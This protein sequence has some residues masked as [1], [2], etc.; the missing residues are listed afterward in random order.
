[1]VVSSSMRRAGTAANRFPVRSESRLTASLCA[2]AFEAAGLWLRRVRRSGRRYMLKSRMMRRTVAAQGMMRRKVAER[3]M[4]RQMM[5]GRRRRG[6]L[7]DS[8][9]GEA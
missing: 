2:S 6:L 7:R 9:T 1:M 4:G 8:I 3:M 5:R